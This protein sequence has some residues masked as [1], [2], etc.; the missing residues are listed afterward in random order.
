MHIYNVSVLRW[1]GVGAAKVHQTGWHSDKE[2][3]RICIHKGEGDAA[4]S[5]VNDG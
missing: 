5:D 3:R 4:R 2:E 1:K